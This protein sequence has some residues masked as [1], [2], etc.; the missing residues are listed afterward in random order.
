MKLRP[1]PPGPPL[2]MLGAL[3]FVLGALAACTDGQRSGPTP[4]GSTATPGALEGGA[5]LRAATPDEPQALLPDLQ[6]MPVRELY[7]EAAEGGRRT[8]RFSTTVLNAGE[9]PLDLTGAHE[10]GTGSFTASQRVLRDDG[11]VAEYE[12]GR[13]LY[14]PGHAHWHVEDFTVLEVWTYTQDGD[15]DAL[16]ASTGKATFCAVDEVPVAPGA[17][18]PSYLECGAEAQGI[19]AGWSDT[20]GAEIAGQELDISGLADGR[21]AIRSAVDPAGRLRE[22]DEGNN[23]LVIYIEIRGTEIAVLSGA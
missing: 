7:I 1:P 21:Y 9:G 11:S 20:Y 4:V 12:V 15:L 2:V 16:A 19:S 10:P 23:S 18:E 13:F 6:T 14:H 3:A 8:L 5:P 17:P 22:S